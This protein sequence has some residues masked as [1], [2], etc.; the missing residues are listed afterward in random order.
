MEIS[1]V[2]NFVDDNDVNCPRMGLM[3][4]ETAQPVAHGAR[5]DFNAVARVHDR[6]TVERDMVREFRHGER[7]KSDAY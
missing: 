1:T 7:Y 6:L 4:A 3:R 5:L 2:A